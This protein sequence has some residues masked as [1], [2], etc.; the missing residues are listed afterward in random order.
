MKPKPN[1][2]I[3]PVV[4]LAGS[5]SKSYDQVDHNHLRFNEDKALEDDL[6]SHVETVISPQVNNVPVVE[7]IVVAVGKQSNS[8]VFLVDQNHL[9]SLGIKALE[10]HVEAVSP[11]QVHM[12]SSSLAELTPV[13]ADIQS[14]SEFVANTPPIAEIEQ[15][16]KLPDT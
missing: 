2:N 14:I 5:A 10:R 3:P 9:N 1:E 13:A 7:N 15:I 8:D 12:T 4:D 6:N 16:P 11:P